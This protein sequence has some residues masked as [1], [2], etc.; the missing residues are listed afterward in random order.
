MTVEIQEIGID[1]LPEYAQ[2]PIAFEVRSILRVDRVDG[3]LGGITLR[4]ET[5]VP[6]YVKDYDGYEDAGPE[7]WPKRFDLNHWGI[8]LIRDG[9]RPV[10]GANV[11]FDTPGIRML[12]DRTDLAVLWDIRVHADFRRHGIGTELFRRAADWARGR[13]LG[14]RAR[15]PPTEGRDATRERACV[16]ILRQARLR[17]GRDQ[18]PRICRASASWPR[19]HAYLVPAP[20]AFHPV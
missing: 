17:A 7:T 9:R 1:S 2:I 11:A 14:P 18:R 5:I 8:F 12:R 4:E 6:A 3:G 20:L 13:R 16:Q 10:G 19:D 15:V